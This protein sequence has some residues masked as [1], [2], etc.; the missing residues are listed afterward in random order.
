MLIYGTAVVEDLDGSPIYVTVSGEKLDEIYGCI[1][2]Q[3][4]RVIGW[5]YDAELDQ[6]GRER[7]S[8]YMERLDV[9]S[10]HWEGGLDV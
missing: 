6:D 4:V 2:Y 10:I 8:D 1:M 3:T 9:E 5:S 7:L